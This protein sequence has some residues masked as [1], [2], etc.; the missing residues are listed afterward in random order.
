MSERY[1]KSVKLEDM[2]NEVLEKIFNKLSVYDVQHNLALVSKQFL[3]VSRIPGMV[4]NVKIIIGPGNIN[5]VYRKTN[6]SDVL[7]NKFSEEQQLEQF[8]IDFEKEKNLCFVKARGII[9]VHPTANIELNYLDGPP[10]EGEERSYLLYAAKEQNMKTDI[11]EVNFLL[12]HMMIDPIENICDGDG[13]TPL[14][15]SAYHGKMEITKMLLQY[16]PTWVKVRDNFGWTPMHYAV[17]L[18]QW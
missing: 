2:P 10:W 3:K 7:P 11:D 9:K 8:K 16:E 1:S 17:C 12:D 13:T 14:H 18:K 15:F 4:N 5:N 6:K